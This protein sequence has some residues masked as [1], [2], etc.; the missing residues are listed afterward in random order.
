MAKVVANS[1]RRKK[2]ITLNAVTKKKQ[3]THI[4]IRKK[5][6]FFQCPRLMALSPT[7]SM[8][9]EQQITVAVTKNFADKFGKKYFPIVLKDSSVFMTSP[10][11]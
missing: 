5:Y 4:D 3:M 8:V 7:H 11:G 10:D 6:F 1:F 9:L 2:K